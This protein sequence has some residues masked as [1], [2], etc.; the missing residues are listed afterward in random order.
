MFEHTVLSLM[1]WEC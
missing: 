1:H